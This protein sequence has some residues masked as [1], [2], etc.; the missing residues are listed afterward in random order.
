[1]ALTTPPDHLVHPVS[2]RDHALGRSDAALTVVVYGDYECPHT[3]L[4]H[5]GLV[6]ARATFG[7]GMRYVYRHYPLR[8]IHP[9]AQHAAEAAEAAG[10]QGR[11]WAMHDWLFHHQDALADADLAAHAAA[12]GLQQVQFERDLAGHAFAARVE[13]DVEMGRRQGVRGTP[14]V[15][16]NGARYEGRIDPVGLRRFVATL[17]G[18]NVASARLGP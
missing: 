7:D 14:T 10:A 8:H 18:K 12:L 6:R 15:F 4:V 11:F 17:A 9:H 5:S 3:R 13:G 16:V 1:M 2:A